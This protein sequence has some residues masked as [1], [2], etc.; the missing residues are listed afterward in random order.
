MGIIPLTFQGGSMKIL[1]VIE[2][3]TSSTLAVIERDGIKCI[4]QLDDT[5]GEVLKTWKL[6]EE[7]I[8]QYVEDYICSIH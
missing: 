8:Q 1:N 4:A 6:P 2:K 3:G 5:T 7:N